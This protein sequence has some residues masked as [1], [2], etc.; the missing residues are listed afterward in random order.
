MFRK[1]ENVLPRILAGWALKVLIAGFILCP[2]ECWARKV[3][4]E[5]FRFSSVVPKVT[6]WSDL[7]KIK[8]SVFKILN[9][10]KY[11]SYLS[12]HING[13]KGC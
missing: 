6:S 1:I 13:Y 10:K 11:N 12:P 2:L 8:N 4:T 5:A 7:N 9:F 3:L